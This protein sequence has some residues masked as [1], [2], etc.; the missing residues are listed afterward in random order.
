MTDSK[1]V[2]RVPSGAAALRMATAIGRRAEAEG[3]YAPLARAI[4]DI[5]V[6]AFPADDAGLRGGGR[7][8]DVVDRRKLR[9]IVDGSE[10]L[11]FSTRELRALD[12]YLEPFGEGL[13]FQP[14]FEKPNLIQTLAGSGTVTFLLSSRPADEGLNFPHWDVLA[15]AE[16]QRQLTSMQMP[17]AI[18]IQDAPMKGGVGDGDASLEPGESEEPWLAHFGEPD[19]SLVCLGSERSMPASALM[20]RRLFVVDESDADADV[21]FHFVWSRG[22]SAA[23]SPF[24]K[25]AAGIKRH[26]SDIA[27]AVIAGRGSALVLSD[28]AFLDTLTAQHRGVGY[29]LCVAQR[30]ANGAVWLLLAG[31]SGPATYATASIAHR[32]R[33]PLAEAHRGEHSPVWWSVVSA[34]VPESHVGTIEGL[35]DFDPREVEPPSAWRPR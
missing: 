20:L 28:Q 2:R 30:R 26:H 5:Y 8:R 22:L 11:V 34:Q 9:A 29:G 23:P 27:E 12:L 17:V 10:E 19:R 31:V 7:A 18:A 21:P 14:L 33:M 35:R 15:M 1:G 16:I 13:S 4:R 32:L 3:G 24:S 6:A 25:R